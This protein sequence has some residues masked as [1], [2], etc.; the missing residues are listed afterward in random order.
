MKESGR[1][2]H[3]SGSD[4]DERKKQR[5]WGRA[6]IHLECLTQERNGKKYFNWQLSMGGRVVSIKE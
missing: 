3:A 4:K 2:R 1:R 6:E 5:K